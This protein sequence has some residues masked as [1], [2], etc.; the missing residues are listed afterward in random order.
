MY[1]RDYISDTRL[2]RLNQIL[3]AVNE[4]LRRSRMELDFYIFEKI[5]VY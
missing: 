3:L 2:K 4:I 5:P 1:L